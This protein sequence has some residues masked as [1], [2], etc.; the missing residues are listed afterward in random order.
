[1][2]KNEA[3]KIE[4]EAAWIGDAVLA[5]YARE[6]VLRERGCMDGIWFTH[7]T[8]NEFLSA[9]G[10]PTSVEA[11]IGNIYRAEGL[12]AAHDHIETKY[13]PLFRKQIVKKTK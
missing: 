3:L 2:T 9:F 13:L 6:F 11:I 4:R 1:M 5:L 10:N 7:L 8:S 12:R